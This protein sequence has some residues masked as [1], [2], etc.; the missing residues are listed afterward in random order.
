MKKTSFIYR[1][2]LSIVFLFLMLSALFGQFVTGLHTKNE[3]LLDK[4]LPQFSWTDYTSSGH[5]IQATF[6]N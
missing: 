2:S 5:F 3:E 4:G 6:E 1:N